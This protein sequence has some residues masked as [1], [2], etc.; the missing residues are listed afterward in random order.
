MV[1]D[2]VAVDVCQ[3]EEVVDGGGE[4]MPIDVLD[5]NS[6][7]DD[8]NHEV[9]DYVLAGDSNDGAVVEEETAKAVNVK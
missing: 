7:D 9:E 6:E 2:A 1:M 4:V 3:Q 5:S 8:D